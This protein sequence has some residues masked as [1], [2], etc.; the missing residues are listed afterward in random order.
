LFLIT[1][2]D[3]IKQNYHPDI[4]ERINR[5]LAKLEDNYVYH[6]DYFYHLSSQM[7][8]LTLEKSNIKIPSYNAGNDLKGFF[9]YLLE[10]VDKIP[11]R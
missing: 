4:H 10:F 9:Y 6:I 8:M 7:I 2:L 1:K 11:D 3:E 5:A